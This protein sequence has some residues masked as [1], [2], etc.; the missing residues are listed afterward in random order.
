MAAAGGSGRTMANVRPQT[1]VEL[2]S[3]RS[4]RRARDGR[5]GRVFLR[6]SMISGAHYLGNSGVGVGE[7][8]TRTAVKFEN[9]TGRGVG[10][11]KRGFRIF[12]LY[13]SLSLSLSLSFSLSRSLSLSISLTRSLSHS[14]SLSFSLS[15]FLSLTLSLS[16]SIRLSVSL[17]TARNAIGPSACVRYD[18]RDTG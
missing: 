2:P 12:S 3:F 8:W 16:L 17:L 6:V 10:R 5:R 18:R 1:A 13:I 7:K 14:I 15:R 9:R 4:R 11:R